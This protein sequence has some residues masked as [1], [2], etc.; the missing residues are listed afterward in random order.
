MLEI[1]EES[2]QLSRQ[3]KRAART[4]AEVMG[5]EKEVGKCVF[6]MLSSTEFEGVGYGEVKGE[7]HE[8]VEILGL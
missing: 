4:T 3:E 7:Q 5:G 2:G 8:M 1:S 6:S